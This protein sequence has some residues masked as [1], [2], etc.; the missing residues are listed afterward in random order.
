MPQKYMW[1]KEER[2]EECGEREE[3]TGYLQIAPSD[4]LSIL[5]E[6][7]KTT[8]MNCLGKF[9]WPWL[10]VGFGQGDALSENQ[11]WLLLVHPLCCG[12]LP[13]AIYLNPP[14]PGPFH[15]GL[16]IGKST[17]SSLLWDLGKAKVP[18][19]CALAFS[20]FNILFNPL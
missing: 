13:P 19:L 5:L 16:L 11:W 1:E 8:D 7:Q 12:S 15:T 18:L 2:K 10:L 14:K 9:S 6:L 4:L 3:S 17:T 20:L